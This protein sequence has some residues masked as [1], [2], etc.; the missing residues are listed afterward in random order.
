[1]TLRDVILLQKREL[2]LRIKEKYV[3]RDANLPGEERRLIK[4]IIGPRRA[5]ISFFAV[6][7]LADRWQSGCV[8]CDDEQLTGTLLP[9]ALFMTL[10]STPPSGHHGCGHRCGLHGGSSK[11]VPYSFSP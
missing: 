11:K 5:G 6:H 4:V 2:D 10:S 7:S 9:P 1:M 3:P 8:N